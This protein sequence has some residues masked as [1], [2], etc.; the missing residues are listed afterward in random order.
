MLIYSSNLTVCPLQV[1]ENARMAQKLIKHCSD[2]DKITFIIRR[3]P[4]AKVFAI[5]RSE[6]GESLGIRREGSTGEVQSTVSPK[7]KYTLLSSWV[8]K[9]EG[10]QMESRGCA[11]LTIEIV[12]TGPNLLLKN[13][14]WSSLDQLNGRC[15]ATR[16]FPLF[17]F[18][19]KNLALTEV[20]LSFGT[21]TFTKCYE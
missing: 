11:T 16:T 12:Q 8:L 17:P 14:A 4:H 18:A 6:N 13:V 5:R 20:I 2:E 10:V 9:T 1:I 7:R 15:D 21:H 3:V 19:F